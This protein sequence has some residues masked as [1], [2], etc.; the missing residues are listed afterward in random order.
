MEQDEVSASAAVSSYEE[1][2]QAV[3]RFRLQAGLTQAQLGKLAD[4]D[5]GTICKF[6]SGAKHIKQVTLAA[7]E[8][9]LSDELAARK[10]ARTLRAER[11]ETGRQAQTST[12]SDPAQVPACGPAAESPEHEQRGLQRGLASCVPLSSYPIYTQIEQLRAENSRLENNCTKY[13]ALMRDAQRMLKEVEKE[14]TQLWK[15]NQKLGERIDSLERVER[16]QARVDRSAVAIQNRGRRI[17]RGIAKVA[18]NEGS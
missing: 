18:K 2:R 10:I 14:N 8:Q 12:M 11:L 1:R 4:V 13:D 17:N 6:E 15:E 9:S 5:R 7:I 16:G 3:R